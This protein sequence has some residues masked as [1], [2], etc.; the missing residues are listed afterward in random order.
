MYQ[1]R[2]G[3]PMLVIGII[4]VVLGIGMIVAGN[5]IDSNEVRHLNSYYNSGHRNNTGTILSGFG[6]AFVVVGAILIILGIVFYVTSGTRSNAQGQRLST[7]TVQFTGRFANSKG[8]YWVELEKNGTCIWSQQGKN[9][10]GLYRYTDNNEWT[11]FINGYGEAFK[12]SV[13]GK[14]IWVTGGPVN[15]VFYYEVQ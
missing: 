6:I 13:K 5:I 14:D 15:E 12:F 11:I 3:I 8:T 9:Y 7:P 2:K 4:M 10:K 1:K